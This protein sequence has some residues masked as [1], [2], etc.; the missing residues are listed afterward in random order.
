MTGGTMSAEETPAGEH[1][2]MIFVGTSMICVLEAIYQ[3]RSGKSVL[4]IDRQ[5]DM[6]GAWLALEIFGLHDVENAIHYFLPD[7][8]AFDF[9]RDTLGWRVIPSERKYQV[10]PAFGLGF[11][12]LP[13][14]NAFARF[15]GK[16]TGGALYGKKR[17]IARKVVRAAREVWSRPP[18][19]YVVGG[20]PEMLSS[21]KELLLSSEV[22][23]A[24]STSIDAI[25][26]DPAAASV[27]V[28]AG[29]RD[30]SATTIFFTH[31]SRI[32][33]LTGPDGPVAIEEK[34]HPRPAVHLLVRDTA[35]A[36]MYECVFTADPL[37][38][39]VHDVT[40]FTR[41]A[42]DLVGTK[43]VLV[44]ALHKDVEP[45]EEIYGEIFARL[46]RVGMVGK[47]ATLE[48]HHW[49][50]AFLPTL[51]DADLD[52]LKAEFAGQVAILRTENFSRGIG[53]NAHRWAD[54]I[55]PASTAG[56]SSGGPRPAPGAGV[57]KQVASV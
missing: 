15:C 4:M 12:R 54:L 45:S 25:H 22:E 33:N 13:Y 46:K 1:F 50:A 39:Y 44:L 43:K 30:F 20:T 19:R 2:D 21:V 34:L 29:S 18:S 11:W 3:S 51:E 31:G 7:P 47:N 26:I 49:L 38:K 27:H 14:D 36:V 35:P 56:S 32:H 42:A 40:R 24:Y 6:G 48:A 16:I 9:M 10:F 8:H 41:E 17:E 52:R 28:R 53:S 23:V 37:V 55:G 57:G 5:A